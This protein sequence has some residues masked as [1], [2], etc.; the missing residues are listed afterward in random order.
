MNTQRVPSRRFCSARRLCTLAAFATLGLGATTARATDYVWTGNGSVNNNWDYAANWGG[1][2]PASSTDNREYF[3]DGTSKTI[4]QNLGNFF[5]TNALIFNSGA[6]AYTING[7]SL[8]FGA[9]NGGTAA[10]ITNSSSNVQTINVNSASDNGVHLNGNLAVNADGKG[11]V[12]GANTNV[13]ADANATLSVSSANGY[14]A[15][16]NGMLTNGSATLSL[17]LVTGANLTLNGVNT[18]SG[19]TTVGGRCSL[20]FG[21]GA[22]SNNSA[23]SMAAAG[24]GFSYV[25]LGGTTI[26]SPLTVNAAGGTNTLY[27][28]SSDA[29][30]Y[31]GSIT[32]NTNLAVSSFGGGLTISGTITGNNNLL[33]GGGG[34]LGANGT[35]T[36]AGAGNN[37]ATGATVV[38]STLLLAKTS[39]A[40]V[41]ALG[42]ALTVN[43]GATVALGGTG[44]DQL[45]AGVAVTLNAGATFQ[46]GGLSEGS[47]VAGSQVGFGTFT[48]AGTAT[49]D[50]GAG[51]NGS[52]LLAAAGVVTGS[53]TI[54]II[55]WSG[56]A[57]ADTGLATND[58]LLFAANP[59]FTAAQLAQ[60]QFKDDNGNNILTGASIIPYNGF[61]ELVPGAAVPEPGTWATLA[62]GLAGAGVVTLRRRR[63]GVAVRA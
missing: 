62:L 60:F 23:I 18:Y 59:N 16:F 24:G 33:A 41:H 36:L 40:N 19:T 22:S 14:G 30:T 61:Y 31:A 1:T 42:G 37:D 4:S 13:R 5:A 21:A 32:L 52:T 44:G 45:A 43:S 49:V 12:F 46:T 20:S 53:G 34:A 27:E 29:S 57:L 51:A 2:V 7:Q 9:N 38:R 8:T 48:L 35:V 25:F 55:N 39:S 17:A 26:T 6:G 3:S 54:N 56:T 15:T 11:I 50:F 63:A 10:F 47:R 28:N 58:R